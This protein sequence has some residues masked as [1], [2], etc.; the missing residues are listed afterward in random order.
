MQILK[1]SYYIYVVDSGQVWYL[2]PSMSKRV[3]DRQ[4][5]SSEVS[6]AASL[7]MKRQNV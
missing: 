2:A 1:P 5:L 6:F 3:F 7:E 4:F